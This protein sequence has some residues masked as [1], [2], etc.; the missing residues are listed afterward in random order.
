[1][2]IY[3]QRTVLMVGL[4]WA[5]GT[6]ALAQN[7]LTADEAVAV[8]LKNSPAVKASGLVVRQNEQL[9]RSA[10]TIPNPDVT[11]DSPSGTFYTLGVQ[12]SFRFPTVY[13]Q[14]AKLQQQQIVL[15]QKEKVV[16]END[17]N[18]RIRTVYLNAQ[19]ADTYLKQ[20]QGQDSVYAQIAIAAKRNFEAG[21]IDKLAL[22]FAET[23]AADVRNQVAVASQELTIA[24][25]QLLLFMNNRQETNEQFALLPLAVR[26]SDR[27]S[28]ANLSLADSEISKNPLVEAAKQMEVINQKTLEVEKASALPGFMVGYYNQS[29]RETN[30]TYRWRVGVSIP[31]W[32]GQYKSR[33]AAAQT[34]QEVARQRTEAQTQVLSVDLQAA[35]GE[36]VKF[37]N[38]LNFYETIALQQANDIINTARRFFE[39]GQTD[40]INFLR[41]TND[42]Y[43]I[44]LRYVET[45]RSYNQSVLTINY[46]KGIL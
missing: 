10:R 25:Q 14:Q 24:K 34:G 36:V 12:Q 23:Q 26:R 33:I 9:V 45:L 3:W 27:L 19:Y 35:Q 21:T 28:F 4:G 2:K 46:L 31:L 5:F 39:S 32:A 7:V 30:L 20:L 8:A 29:T 15:A 16:T 11:L 40:Y 38:S 43:Q 6:L 13:T 17:L 41:T 44:R 1:M 22:I 18:Y 42:A 37:Q